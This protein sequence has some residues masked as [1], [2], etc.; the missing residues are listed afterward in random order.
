VCLLIVAS[1]VIEGTPLLIAANRDEFLIRP[2]SPFGTLSVGPPQVLGGR[3]QQSGGTWLTINRHGVFAGL[4]NQPLGENK[5]PTLRSRGELPLALAAH[6]TAKD[7]VAAFVKGYDP[8]RYNGCWLLVGDRDSLFFID[9]TAAHELTAVPLPPGVH[10]LENK[11]L[12][13]PS[14]KAEHVRQLLG[15]LQGSPEAVRDGLVRVLSDHVVP[16]PTADVPK[17][18]ANC[19]HL[20]G[21]G[22]RSSCVIHCED[23]PGQPPQCRVADG[24]PCTTA[25]VD[26]SPLWSDA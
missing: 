14:P 5:D 25:L 7:A 6:P 24:P 18:S 20:D 3:D 9:F 15:P 1:R 8:L 26:V 16:E 17:T 19:I 22:T 12:G 23:D 11:A 21:Y 4:T 13:V 2:T 10:I